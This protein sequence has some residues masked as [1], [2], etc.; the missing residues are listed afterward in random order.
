MLDWFAELLGKFA[1]IVGTL[2]PT[3]PFQ[4]YLKE[5]SN[6][7]YLG[8]INWVVPVGKCVK[9]GLAWLSVIA[10]F[11]LYSIIMRWVKM[12]GD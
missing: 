12:I 10:V 5:F 1:N 4:P 2:L 3:S 6:L 11:Y 8:Y 7:P 9:I